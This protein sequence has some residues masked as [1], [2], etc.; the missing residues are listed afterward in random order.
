MYNY[1]TLLVAKTSVINMGIKIHNSLPPELKRIENFKVFKNKL[2]SYLL[3]NCFY[4][5]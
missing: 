4:W 2:K 1:A 3:Q 5:F